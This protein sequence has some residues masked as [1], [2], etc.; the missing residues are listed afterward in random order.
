MQGHAEKAWTSGGS[1]QG[2]WWLHKRHQAEEGTH[3][4]MTVV[5]MEEPWQS[6]W[7]GKVP[8]LEGILLLSSFCSRETQDTAPQTL[9]SGVCSHHF[10]EQTHSLPQRVYLQFSP[11]LTPTRPRRHRGTFQGPK[12]AQEIC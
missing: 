9:G 10:P 12:F 3:H 5:K 6:Y 8:G 2:F 11:G 7:C 4:D 1:A